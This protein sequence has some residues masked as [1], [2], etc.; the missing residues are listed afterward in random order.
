[1]EDPAAVP[2]GICYSNP[3]SASLAHDPNGDVHW[4]GRERRSRERTM[5]I[6]RG[7]CSNLMDDLNVP[8]RPWP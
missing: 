3:V 8:E 1:M 5:L 4:K 2:G 6:L 7:G